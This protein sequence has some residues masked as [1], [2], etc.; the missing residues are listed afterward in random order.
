MTN[1]SHWHAVNDGLVAI[2]QVDATL[3]DAYG[4]MPDGKAYAVRPA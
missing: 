4:P 3:K 2:R 1:R